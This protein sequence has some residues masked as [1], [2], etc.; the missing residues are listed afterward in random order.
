MPVEFGC[1]G[2]ARR[3]V[4]EPVTVYIFQKETG[5]RS[6]PAALASEVAGVVTERRVARAA[7]AEPPDP[8]M[9]ARR[10]APDPRPVATPSRLRRG[11]SSTI[12]KIPMIAGP[13]RLEPWSMGLDRR[14]GGPGIATDLGGSWKQAEAA[15]L[16]RDWPR[17]LAGLGGGTETHSATARTLLAEA[18]AESRA[19]PRK[20]T[21]I[22]L[23]SGPRR[24]I[25]RPRR[26]PG[27]PGSTA[28]GPRSPARSTPA[29]RA[30]GR[31]GRRAPEAIAPDRSS[32]GRPSPRSPN[33]PTTRPGTAWTAG[34]APMPGR[35]ST[36]GSRCWSGSPPT[37]TPATP[38]APTTD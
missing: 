2:Q 25:P 21:R 28:Q 35:P 37:L 30:R 27:E 7:S 10:L 38:T 17:A 19:R 16:A 1:P 6:T 23:S 9:P 33:C 36:P 32:P 22:G 4:L 31:V 11:R 18:R 8:L 5:L 14:L 12:G 20:P 34:S 29:R 3:R 24:P 13:G 26:E 15:T